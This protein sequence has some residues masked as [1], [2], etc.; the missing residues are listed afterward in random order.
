MKYKARILALALA[1]L[2]VVALFAGCGGNG[3][4]K[5][6]SAA[7]SAEAAATTVETFDYEGYEFT[8]SDG[9]YFPQYTETGSPASQLD[10]EWDDLYTALEDKYNIEIVCQPIQNNADTLTALTA[11]S[12]AGN[13]LADLIRCRQTAYWPAGKKNIILPVDGEQLVSLGLDSTDETRWFQPPI[14]ETK[15]WGNAWGLDVASK[16][17]PVKTGYFVTFNKGMIASNT[18][19]TDLYKLVRDKKWTWDVYLDIAQDCTKDTNGDGAT[20]QWGCGATAWGNEITTNGV[21]YVGPDSTGKWVVLL[22]CPEGIDSLNFLIAENTTGRLDESS[23]TCRQAFADGKIAF[24][25]ANMGHLNPDSPCY[26]SVFDY[27][28][29]PM[30][31][32]PAAT[33]YVAS[34][35]DNDVLVIQAANPN[36][37]KVVKIMNDWA[38]IVNDTKSYLEVLGDG[39]CRTTEDIEM[40][41]DYIIPNFDLTHYEITDPIHDAIDSGIVSGVSYLGMT[42]Q[43]AIETYKG[44]VQV[45]LDEFFNS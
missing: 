29:I 4:N 21:D 41:A 32:G 44:Q 9:M 22:D 15:V 27:G 11:A 6:T 25:W 7:T 18:T 45:L 33:G 37:D 10:A 36:L 2:M 3:D 20:D 26:N 5:D 34:F 17:V 24:N 8:I 14:N 30:P 43:Q 39:R 16:F 23:G 19:Y 13:T 12:M 38:L 31:M 40:M 1:I 42:A 35:D 28:I